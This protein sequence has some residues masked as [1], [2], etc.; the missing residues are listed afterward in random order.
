MISSS[1]R[2]EFRRFTPPPVTLS[3]R[4]LHKTASLSSTSPAVLHQEDINHAIETVQLN[5][6]LDIYQVDSA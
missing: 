2:T 6:P 4:L 5:D 1:K 3:I